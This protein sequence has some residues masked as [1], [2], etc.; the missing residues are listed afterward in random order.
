[1]RAEKL[2]SLSSGRIYRFQFL[3]PENPIRQDEGVAMVIHDVI[4]GN[5]LAILAVYFVGGHACRKAYSRHVFIIW[6]DV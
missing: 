2:T 6:M 5:F 1:M 4:P 3:L